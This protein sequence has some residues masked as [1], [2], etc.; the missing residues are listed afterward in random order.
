MR[1]ELL[2]ADATRTDLHPSLTENRA[3]MASRSETASLRN[4]LFSVLNF[5]LSAKEIRGETW[6]EVL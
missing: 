2:A 5:F 1:G 3:A 6:R 4:N